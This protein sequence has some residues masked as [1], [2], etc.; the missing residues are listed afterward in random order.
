MSVGESR[1]ESYRKVFRPSESLLARWPHLG[2]VLGFCVFMIAY[3]F[4]NVYGMSFSQAAASPFGFSQFGLALRAPQSRCKKWWL[5]V[6]AP[7]PIRLFSKALMTFLAWFLLA[8][9]VIDAAKLVSP[10]S[11]YADSSAIH[12][13][14]RCRNLRSSVWLRSCW[15]RQLPPLAPLLRALP[16]ET[17]IGSRGCNGSWGTR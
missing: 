2:D 16:S 12:P 5:L 1:L 9:F 3:Y 11:S 7:L 10:H 6:L 14:K 15:Y 4:A 17:I 13:L 8:T